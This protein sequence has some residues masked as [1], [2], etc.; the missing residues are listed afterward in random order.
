MWVGASARDERTG[1]RRWWGKNK[2]DEQTDALV[3][4]LKC[5][6]GFA[7][8]ALCGL[9][10]EAVGA[11]PPRLQPA[12]RP[13]PGDAARRGEPLQQVTAPREAAEGPGKQQA[14]G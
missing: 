9:L 6:A 13:A 10:G 14:E 11:G 2:G 7:R 12:P 1:W 8:L 4:D 5:L 3:L